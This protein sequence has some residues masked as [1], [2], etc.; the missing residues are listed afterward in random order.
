MIHGI[1]RRRVAASRARRRAR[2]PAHGG[3]DATD[4]TDASLTRPA[5]AAT[6][7]PLLAE[8]GIERAVFTGAS[9]EE[10]AAEVA[11]Y[12]PNR[13]NVKPENLRRNLRQRPDGRWE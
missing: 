7:P 3:S 8:L 1:A 6:L 4:G 5:I 2:S 10:A 12:L 11:G 13:A 9:L